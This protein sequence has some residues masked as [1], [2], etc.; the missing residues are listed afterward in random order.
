MKKN[1]QDK[2]LSVSIILAT[3]AL[4]FYGLSEA[5]ISINNKS[6][7]DIF[8]YLKEDYLDFIIIAYVFICFQ[9]SGIVELKYKQ[10]FMTTS[11]V[12]IIF[13]PLSLFF[14][15]KNKNNSSDD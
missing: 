3:I 2:I 10:D 8:F 12:C 4:V 7:R 1:S 14:I 15:I 6:F 13:T 11:L 5:E 9:I